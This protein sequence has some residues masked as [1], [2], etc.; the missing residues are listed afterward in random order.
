MQAELPDGRCRDV[1]ASCA[2][3]RMF[4]LRPA[5]RQNEGTCC[6]RGTKH[7]SDALARDVQAG[8]VS[9]GVLSS[10]RPGC[11][12]FVRGPRECFVCLA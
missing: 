12:Q 7:Y 10:R 3:N 9:A 8:G 4:A 5:A 1:S 6:M 11:V 2:Y